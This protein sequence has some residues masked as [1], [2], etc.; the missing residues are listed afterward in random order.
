M[1]GEDSSTIILNVYSIAAIMSDDANEGSVIE[2]SHGLTVEVRESKADI[3]AI[4]D[5]IC[6]DD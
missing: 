1:W 2:Y 4:I 5:D 3:V 6:S